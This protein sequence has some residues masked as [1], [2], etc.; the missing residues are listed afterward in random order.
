MAKLEGNE[1]AN[2]VDTFVD[3]AHLENSFP[4]CKV[5]FA[6]E[7]CSP[8]Y[9]ISFHSDEDGKET[10]TASHYDPINAGPYPQDKPPLNTVRFT[11]KQ[12]E[13]IRSGVNAGLTMV[14]GP[15]GTGKTDVAVQIIM[16]L[17][18]NFPNQK[19]LLVT[20]S[21]AALN[22]LFE[23]IMSRDIDPRHLLRLGSGERELSESL[24]QGGAA[25]SGR[26]QGEEFSKQ[27]RV[28]W[29]LARRQELLGVVQRLAESLNI[30][31]DVGYSCETSSYFYVD[32]IQ[33]R[34][35]KFDMVVAQGSKVSASFPFFGYFS[36][37]AEGLFSGVEDSDEEVARGCFRHV[38]KI[39]EE[40][41][42]YRA[43]ELLRTQA[44]RSD[45][46]LT[47]QA[48]IVA[49]TC[50]HAAMTRQKLVDLGFK[51]DRLVV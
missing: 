20:H 8:P 38:N 50:T 33:P 14:V 35:K 10:V 40:L 47:K 29:S 36:D 43:F 17:Y 51:Y 44:H 26:G 45:Y 13:A 48:R 32:H 16:N 22:D 24:A 11:A 46:L 49:M 3:Q 1:K 27:G 42:D 37:V 34:L 9:R 5:S 28:N 12:V 2:Y 30:T 6:T 19:I 23:K 39:F 4:N 21:N 31:G 7:S 18:H 25:G 15:P 41:A